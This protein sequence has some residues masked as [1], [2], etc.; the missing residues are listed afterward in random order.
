MG[1]AVPTL[2]HREASHAHSDRLLGGARPVASDP[3]L[4][5]EPGRLR[6][7]AAIIISPAAALTL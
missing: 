2:S 5:M 4:V 1:E 3:A 7:L 6:L